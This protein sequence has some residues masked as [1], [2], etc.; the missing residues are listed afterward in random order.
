[1]D[2]RWVLV[3][4]CLVVAVLLAIVWITQGED[5]VRKRAA[6]QLAALPPVPAEGKCR[7]GVYVNATG[8]VSEAGPNALTA[9]ISL[10][11]QIVEVESAPVTSAEEIVSALSSQALSD[12]I[13]IVV[14]REGRRREL[15]VPCL[16]SREVVQ[17]RRQ[18]AQA[19]LERRW[20]DCMRVAEELDAL[21]GPSAFSAQLHLDCYEEKS[22][23]TDQQPSSEHARLLFEVRSREIREIAS[24]R[25][26]LEE[27]RGDVL[28]TVT[29]LEDW[30][31]G[32]L[33]D[34]L[35]DQIDSAISEAR[36][37]ALP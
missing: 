13:E 14:E 37:E 2:G 22:G 18:A 32:D 28:A 17:L 36:S 35:R 20:D 19:A 4:G 29:Q 26:H 12:R 9:G 10:G 7:I 34:E 3:L 30:G 16:D 21:E 24:S 31:F 6:E 11:D 8:I 25:N 5:P 27:K 15:S 1:M 33:A 23:R